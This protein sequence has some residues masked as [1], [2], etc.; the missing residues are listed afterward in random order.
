MQHYLTRKG[1]PQSGKTL[2]VFIETED[3][4]VYKTTGLVGENKSVK[5]TIEYPDPDAALFAADSLFTRYINDDGYTPSVSIPDKFEKSRL[6]SSWNYFAEKL[7]IPLI[8]AVATYYIPNALK[9]E[10]IAKIPIILGFA[11]YAANADE[12]K[13][14]LTNRIAIPANKL[15]GKLGN[16]YEF[17]ISLLGSDY[18]ELLKGLK[19]N[20]V[21]IAFVPPYAYLTGYLKRDPALDSFALIGFKYM[22]TGIWYY[23][24]V[25]TNK[26]DG[27]RTIGD[28]VAL[29]NNNGN[30]KITKHKKEIIFIVN[31]KASTS[32]YIVPKLF[33]LEKIRGQVVTIERSKK[34]ML[35][36]V[37]STTGDSL[38]FG[39]FSSDDWLDVSRDHK[40]DSMLRFLKYDAIPIPYDPVLFNCNGQDN[41]FNR[42]CDSPFNPFCKTDEKRKKIIEALRQWAYTDIK[43]DGARNNDWLGYNESFIDYLFSG[44]IVGKDSGEKYYIIKFVPDA[45]HASLLLHLFDSATICLKY[46]VLENAL[47]NS[48][49]FEHDSADFR[50]PRRFIY[51]TVQIASNTIIPLNEGYGIKVPCYNLTK[52]DTVTY[53]VI[54]N[55]K[56]LLGNSERKDKR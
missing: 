47:P 39:F 31:E 11:D 23:P 54:D 48:P 18:S 35:E 32:T 22:S 2:Y 25:I 17:I 34:E 1:E 50:W 26:K 16:E 37:K 15:L 21:D 28:L 43:M 13:K 3:V 6:V 4:Y 52:I 45:L 36:M 7:L 49:G 55:W 40:N 5:E 8:L 53:V 27:L 9:F 20:R 14:E 56:N 30:K 10:P 12:Q 46:G 42:K 41:I 19:H 44:V 38:V 29:V 24:G 51:D 33:M